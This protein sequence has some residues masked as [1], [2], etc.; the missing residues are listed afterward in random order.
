MKRN[1]SL[2]PFEI[3]SWHTE[4]HGTVRDGLAIGILVVNLA[5]LIINNMSTWAS[6]SPLSLSFHICSVITFA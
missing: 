6:S 2:S 5:L 3:A 4:Q 1:L